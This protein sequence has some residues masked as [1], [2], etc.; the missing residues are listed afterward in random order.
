[1]ISPVRRALLFGSVAVALTTSLRP[2]EADGGAPSVPADKPPFYSFA[3]PAL[4]YGPDANE[5]SID[6]ETMRL[7]HGRHHAVYVTNLNAALM[8]DAA[9]HD[10]SLQDLLARVDDLPE[11]IRAT[12]RN[13]A[14]GHA[15]HTMFWQVM[16]GRGGAPEGELEATITRDFGAFASLRTAFDDA[17]AGVF[18]SGWAMV[19]MDRDGALSLVAEANQ[20]SPPID[21]RSALFGNDVWEHAY[22][23][24]HR[25]RRPDYLA[26]WWNVLD[27][28]RIGARQALARSGQIV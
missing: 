13:K 19:V 27:W 15:N 3:V 2:A 4:P 9:L 5:P 22:H 17:A 12:V 28:T 16:G 7:H 20:D 25:N 24:G 18:G 23:P 14:G 11:P 21:G 10:V 1:M 6:A 26:A 8:D